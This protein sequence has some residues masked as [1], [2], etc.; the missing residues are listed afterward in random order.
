MLA[1]WVSVVAPV[2][3]AATL[4]RMNPRSRGD[5]TDVQRCEIDKAMSA[6]AVAKAVYR[7]A[8]PGAMAEDASFTEVSNSAR[9]STYTLQ[10]WTR[11]AVA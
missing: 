11:E 9:H 3:G 8:G 2:T 4:E 6:Y 10:R 7:N 1:T 5:L